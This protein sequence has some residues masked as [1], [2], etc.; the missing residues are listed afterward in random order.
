MNTAY[1]PLGLLNEVDVIDLSADH[2][3]LLAGS[4]VHFAK[5]A[6]GVIRLTDYVLTTLSF[7]P[8]VGQAVAADLARREIAVYN[9]ETR[10]FFVKK[11]FCW[12]KTPAEAGEGSPWARQVGNSLRDVRCPAVREAV[13]AAIDSADG[14]EKLPTVGIPT[15][16]LTALPR[17]PS[18]K[19]W[20]PSELL[21]LLA[22]YIDQSG[23]A[24]GLLIAD[25]D[26]LGSLC[27]LPPKTVL[28]CIDTLT[29]GEAIAFDS[30]SHETYV[31]GRIKHATSNELGCIAEAVDNL[32][33]R[34]VKHASKRH[35]SRSF[36]T[37]SNKSTTS[38]PK[39]K[40]GKENKK[41]GEENKGTS[42]DAAGLNAA[43]PPAATAFLT[44]IEELR[45]NG[46][47]TK[48]VDLA[49]DKKRLDRIVD[50]AA[51]VGEQRVL[52]VIEGCHYPLEALRACEAV[53]SF[54]EAVRSYNNPVLAEMAKAAKAVR[55]EEL[56][57]LQ[58]E[59]DAAP[60]LQR[61]GGWKRVDAL[62]PA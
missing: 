5:V 30:A 36:P 39:E 10:E 35:F 19:R 16:L 2:K 14:A 1:F 60:Q 20:T 51:A 58:A 17:T 12:N 3:L 40:K 21:L 61:N 48:E 57:R 50:F 29:A 42:A 47:R 44:K 26:A 18:G 27:S 13:Q 11:Y 45:K 55:A 52:E 38:A 32:R 37:F 23:A 56:A 9:P 22:L 7:L 31:F 28:E 24:P 62:V 46:A 25:Q 6:C 34:S 43:S 54:L 59:A 33:S 49:T 8:G 41:K 4:S 53:P 15:N